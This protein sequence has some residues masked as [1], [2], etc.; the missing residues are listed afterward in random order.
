MENNT[1]SGKSLAP[2]D[3][4]SPYPSESMAYCIDMVKR[5]INDHGTN[6][7]ISREEVANSLD[8]AVPTIIMKISSCVQYG[9]LKSQHGIGYF[10]SDL[11]QKYLQP[12]YDH[13]ER[14]FLLEMFKTPPL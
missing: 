9:M 1:D 8:K 12:V 7:A 14:K 10:I 11:F 5:I 6:E 2:K 3:E 13:D 4:R